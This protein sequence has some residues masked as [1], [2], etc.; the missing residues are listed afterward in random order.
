MIQHII[1]LTNDPLRKLQLLAKHLQRCCEDENFRHKEM[2]K[3]KLS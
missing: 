1:K 2:E 3:D